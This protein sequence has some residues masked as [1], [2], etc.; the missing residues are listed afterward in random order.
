MNLIARYYTEEWNDF[1]F[2][3]PIYLDE[4]FEPHKFALV[5]WTN[6]EPYEAVSWETG[7]KVIK[8]RSCFVIAWLEWNVK[9]SYFEF[10]SCGM[11]Y[12]EYRIDGLE[13]FIMN[14]ANQM[15]KKLLED[16][17]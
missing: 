13:D 3:A 1:Q 16:Y 2:Q 7:E 10:R 12:F 5:K 17:E 11:R 8:T 4:H 14:F 15:E 6:H 9:E